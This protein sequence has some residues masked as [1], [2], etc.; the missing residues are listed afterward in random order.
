YKDIL[1]NQ[2]LR[3][4]AGHSEYKNGHELRLADFWNIKHPQRLKKFF[5]HTWEFNLEGIN[6]KIMRTKHIPDNVSSWRESMWSCGVI[7]NN[8]VFFTSDTRYDPE[9]ILEY[10]KFFNFEI[11]FHDCQFFT[12]GVHASLEEIKD[13][14]AAV[15]KKTLLMHYGDNFQQYNSKIKKY[16]FKG[17]ALQNHKYIFS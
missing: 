2:S 17:F 15:K 9:L 12:G 6:I 8:R 11:I 14:P 16:G 4:G 1:W 5:R 13:L 10:D 7:I 3:G